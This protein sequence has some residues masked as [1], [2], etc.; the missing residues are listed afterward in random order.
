MYK[1]SN[2]LVPD[3]ISD[4]IPPRVGE[5]INYP[6]RNGLNLTNMYI[7]TEISRKSCIPSSVSNW[8]SLNNDIRDI[9]SS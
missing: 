9:D 3:Y 5:I 4:T 8:N 7:R 2:N 6:L 1:C